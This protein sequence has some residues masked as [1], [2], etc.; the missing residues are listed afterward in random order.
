MI[1]EI[2][3]HLLCQALLNHATWRSFGEIGKS[4]RTVERMN[5]NCFQILLSRLLCVCVSVC[6]ESGA[7]FT[8]MDETPF[9]AH[10]SSKTIFIPVCPQLFSNLTKDLD[11]F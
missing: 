7:V 4:L 2:Y 3:Q 9:E 8:V 10:I 1:A 5:S 6:V 11:H